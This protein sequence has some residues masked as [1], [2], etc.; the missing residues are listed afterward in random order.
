M[1]RPDNI[2]NSLSEKDEKFVEDFKKEFVRRMEISV[3]TYLPK[4]T[5]REKFLA[6][7]Y[8]IRDRLIADWI[9]TKNVYYDSNDKK[10]YYLSMEFLMG[11]TLGNTVINLEMEKVVNK[12]LT[13]LGFD[14]ETLEEI[15]WD[16]GL[17]NGGLG[18]LA[19]C[20]LDSM[21]TM[22]LPAYG[23][24]IRYEFGM[25]EQRII[26]NKQVEFPDTWLRHGNPFEMERGEEDCFVNFGGKVVTVEVPGSDENKTP[27]IKHQWVDYDQVVAV[28]YDTPVPGFK[29]ENV[30]TLRLWSS[31]ATREFHLK[32][33]DEGD[34][35]GAVD[36]K[37]HSE[38][39]SKVLYPNDNHTL[40][41]E[42][43]FRQQYF[44]VSASIQDVVRHFKKRGNNIHTLPEKVV[45]QLNDTHPT[46]AI[47]E[48][49]RIL[50]DVE[51]LGWDE[52]WSIVT[53]TFAYTN[54]TLLPEA[55]E[56][57]PVSLFEK[58]LPRHLQII[59]E[60]NHRFLEEVA[61]AYPGDFKKRERMSLIEEGKEKQIRMANLAIAGSFS[62]NGVAE[63][64]SR[65]LTERVLKDFYDLYPE[66]FNNKTNG[67]TPRRWLRKANPSLCRL[68]SK[69]INKPWLKNLDALREL[70][71]CAK[72]KDFLKRWM[73]I[74]RQNKESLAKVIAQECDQKVNIDSIFDV[75]VKRIHEY[76]RQLLNVLHCIHMYFQ[77]KD[78]PNQ[79]FIPRTVIFGGKAAPGYFLA[80]LI[81]NLINSVGN[82]VNNDKSI[83]DQLKVIFIPNYSVSLAQIIIP[84]SDLSEQISTA[85]YEASGTGNMKFALNGAL[86]IG[87]LDG[88]NIEIKEEVGDENIFIFGKTAE[89]IEKLKTEGYNSQAIYEHCPF[90]KRIL[91]SIRDGHFSA[92]DPTRF[93]PI[94]DSL[95]N[96]NDPFFLLSDFHAY[97]DCQNA[98]AQLYSAPMAWHEKAILN[99]VR[100]GKF[101]SDRVISEYANEIWNVKPC[102]ISIL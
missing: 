65:L 82:V 81:I 12:A 53:K 29:T 70:E 56:K 8:A 67:I 37:N 28:A 31:R 21:A 98:V 6:L 47:P 4:S 27:R 66:K 20:F 80:K 50:L 54:H 14:M 35:V 94:F 36:E 26:D 72:D 45:I 48:L 62:V 7:A 24:G 64:H 76:K 19:A 16:A 69:T 60:I 101:S 46:L 88:A 51:H 79:D 87:T 32:T 78:N 1:S 10:V 11:R 15:E 89:E 39:I 41:K 95:V 55:L 17:G 71:P 102:P 44:M 30:N 9:K 61:Q 75:Q 74:K 84:G 68:I 63:L 100:M 85:G 5:D 99:C 93:K 25:F 2:H 18:R 22:N 23:Y 43:R 91:N 90:L 57:W 73:T 42:L 49:M 40:G 77:I 38:T 97:I 96:D 33:F 13:D 83:R 34:Y 86:T 3:G 92:D 58:I 59:Y 52:A